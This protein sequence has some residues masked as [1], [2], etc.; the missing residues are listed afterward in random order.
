MSTDK[1]WQTAVLT[2]SPAPVRDGDGDGI[3]DFRGMIERLDHLVALG[4]DAVWLSPYFAQLDWG[5]D[6]S[7][8]TARCARRRPTCVPRPRRGPRPRTCTP[9]YLR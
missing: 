6:I 9:S 5:R 3:G 1:W 2:R 8:F 7:D 4:I